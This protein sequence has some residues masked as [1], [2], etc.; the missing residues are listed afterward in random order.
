MPNLQC[1][2]CGKKILDCVEN[3]GHYMNM[4]ELIVSRMKK[5]FFLYT[6]TPDICHHE[7]LSSDNCDGIFKLEHFSPTPELYDD[8]D[9]FKMLKNNKLN[10]LKDRMMEKKSKL[11]QETVKPNAYKSINS[12]SM[13]MA[14]NRCFKRKQVENPFI[15][16]TFIFAFLI[17]IYIFVISLQCF[18]NNVFK[19]WA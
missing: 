7:V 18:V 15:F 6:I 2:K 8:I 3:S 9:F 14:N 11:F 16:K 5:V 4:I 1:C 17:R 19:K 12:S 10:T 13:T